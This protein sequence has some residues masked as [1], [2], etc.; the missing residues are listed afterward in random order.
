MSRVRKWTFWLRRTAIV[1]R[2]D[3]G[4]ATLRNERNG[5][6]DGSQTVQS[7]PAA[8]LTSP[9]TSGIER[10]LNPAGLVIAVVASSATAMNAPPMDDARAPG[11]ERFTINWARASAPSARRPA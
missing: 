10:L 9:Y 2:G 3:S 5:E 8:L 7:R 1:I 4:M 6:R 11:V